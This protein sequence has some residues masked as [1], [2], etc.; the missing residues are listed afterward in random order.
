[1]RQVS[2]YHKRLICFKEYMIKD[3]FLVIIT[4]DYV[5]GARDQWRLS[6][7]VSILEV[8]GL[9]DSTT[10]PVPYGIYLLFVSV[11]AFVAPY[12]KYNS[13]VYPYHFPCNVPIRPIFPA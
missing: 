2:S 3:H 8:D 9:M 11:M 13:P 10:T 6:Y 7:L 4:F 1:M 12:Y 5:R